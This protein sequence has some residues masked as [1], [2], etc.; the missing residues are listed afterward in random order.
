[1]R[2]HGAAFA[3]EI[4]GP[5]RPVRSS[6]VWQRKGPA[7]VPHLSHHVDGRGL[8]PQSADS[9]SASAS[10]FPSEVSRRYV[11]PFTLQIRTFP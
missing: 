4:P 8:V 3:R 9:A 1:M 6:G 7:L 11:M 2:C 5:S 10:A